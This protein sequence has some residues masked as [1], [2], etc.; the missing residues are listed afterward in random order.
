MPEAVES[1]RSPLG[2]VQRLGREVNW[3]AVRT[4]VLSERKCTRSEGVSCAG[5]GVLVFGTSV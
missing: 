3:G 5:C 4:S 2:S 1:S